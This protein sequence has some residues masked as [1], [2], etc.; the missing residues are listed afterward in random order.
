[1]LAATK[2]PHAT[3]ADHDQICALQSILTFKF[4][5]KMMNGSPI[6][7]D[8][9]VTLRYLEWKRFKEAHFSVK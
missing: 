7:K 9:Q 1:V 5:L 2:F 6:L 4:P 3:C 8:E